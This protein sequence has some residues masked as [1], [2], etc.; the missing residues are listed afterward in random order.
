LNDIDYCYGFH[1]LCDWCSVNEDC[2]K[3]NGTDMFDFDPAYGVE[4]ENLANLKKQES[5]IK[6]KKKEIEQ[7]I[8]NTYH[9]VNGNNNGWLNTENYRFKV[10]TMAGRKS[11]DQDMLHKQITGHIHDGTTANDLLD[12]CQKTSSPYERLYIS[13]INK[14]IINAA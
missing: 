14:R 4:L 10:S 3:F 5:A 8:K 9:L 7:R 11:L 2:P 13:K 12:K 1:P 6:K